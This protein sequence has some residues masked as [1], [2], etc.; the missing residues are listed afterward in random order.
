MDLIAGISELQ[1]DPV[2]SSGVTPDPDD[3]YLVALAL[4]TEADYLISGDA[5]LTGLPAS[6]ARVVT[7][8]A[9]AL[10]LEQAG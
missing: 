3:D 8:T 7:P 9:F 6:T 5:D 1:P 4:A 10:F 2:V